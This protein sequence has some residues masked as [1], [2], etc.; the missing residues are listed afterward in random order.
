[1]TLKYYKYLLQLPFSSHCILFYEAYKAEDK[2]AHV[3][4]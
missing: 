2:R 4:L 1:M 3:E